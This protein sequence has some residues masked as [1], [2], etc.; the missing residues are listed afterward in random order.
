V[1]YGIAF[2]ALS[3]SGGC[4]GSPTTGTR[5]ELSGKLK[6]QSASHGKRMQEYYA[7]KKAT[8]KA[9]GR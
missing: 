8:A 3:V 4:G 1:L 2:G 5:E 6:E 9:K 7:A